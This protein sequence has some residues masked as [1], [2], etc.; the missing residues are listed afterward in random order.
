MCI[1]CE[2]SSILTLFSHNNL[3]QLKSGLIFTQVIWHVAIRI[4]S[5]QV[6]PTNCTHRHKYNN[7]THVH[8]KRIRLDDWPGTHLGVQSFRNIHT[9]AKCFQSWVLFALVMCST[10]CSK[11]QCHVEKKKKKSQKL[12][13][14]WGAAPGQCAHRWQQRAEVS[15]AHCRRRWHRLQHP[16]DTAP[17]PQS[18]Q[19]STDKQYGKEF[20]H[21]CTNMP[22]PITKANVIGLDQQSTV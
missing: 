4:N 21:L 2:D 19:C 14:E 15:T 3:Q 9:L 20:I 12:T 5:Q 8:E 10:S 6:S 22:N 17:P 11:R 16:A 13:L 1:F 7:N 18:H